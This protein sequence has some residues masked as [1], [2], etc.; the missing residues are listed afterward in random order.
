MYPPTRVDRATPVRAAP[1]SPVSRAVVAAQLAAARPRVRER[2][3]HTSGRTPRSHPNTSAADGRTDPHLPEG[4]RRDREVGGATGEL[5]APVARSWLALRRSRCR[6]EPA[7][8]RS[9]TR[10]APRATARASSVR[11]DA[12]GARARGGAVPSSRRRRTRRSAVDDHVAHAVDRP[13]GPA[14]RSSS[15]AWTRSAAR[16]RSTSS[17]PS[18]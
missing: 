1:R 10:R 3:R 17:W 14:P 9:A 7:R 11:C 6:A 8:R 5:A 2:V 4:A 13:R 18:R 15:S 12:G 16:P